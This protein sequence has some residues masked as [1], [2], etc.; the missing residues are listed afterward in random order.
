MVVVTLNEGP[1]QPSDLEL[2]NQPHH[3]PTHRQRTL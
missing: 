1:Q 2:D 3:A